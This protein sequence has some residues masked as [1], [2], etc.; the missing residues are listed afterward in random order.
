MDYSIISRDA[1]ARRQYAKKVDQQSTAALLKSPS[2]AR[3]CALAA[4][5]ANAESAVCSELSMNELFMVLLHRMSAN[6]TTIHAVSQ[7]PL[8][9]LWYRCENE[10]ERRAE[11]QIPVM[12]PLVEDVPA[13]TPFAPAYGI[14][15]PDVDETESYMVRHIHAEVLDLESEF[16]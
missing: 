10:M 13:R 11:D 3:S 16:D 1:L 6:P 7:H 15:D 12:E 8:A 9:D 14:D 2:K 5:I 4:A